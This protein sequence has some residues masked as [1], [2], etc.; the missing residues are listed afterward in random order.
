MNLIDY[1]FD[2]LIMKENTNGT[3][4]RIIAVFKD[5]YELFC[6]CGECFGRLKSSVYYGNKTEEFPTTGDFVLINY[7]AI[8]DSRI[9][10]TLPRKSKFVRNDFSGHAAA[11]V[12]NFLE[13]I[14]AVNFDYV[15]IMA[16]LNHD[17][18]IKRIERYLTLAFTS[19]AVPVII[20]SKAD[21]VN[22]YS[23]QV[24]SVENIATGVNVHV[25]SAVTG[26]GLDSLSIYL[27]PQKTIVFLGS[28]GVGKSS[29]VNALAGE[30]IMTVNTIREDDSKGKHTTTVRQLIM[31][32]CGVMIID[33]PGMREMGMWDVKDG[34]G[35]AFIDVEKYFGKCKFSD[36]KHQSEPGCAVKDAIIN[37]ELS[38]TRW[39]SY[40]NLKHEAK[41]ADDKSAYLKEK[42]HWYKDIAKL[43]KQL[44]KSGHKNK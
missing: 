21:L 16:S 14:V 25:I 4:A 39:D 41:Y 35:E 23:E 36:C 17:F 27:K 7:N 42:Q 15:F 28:S 11:Y 40:I 24:I 38:K 44:H 18:N 37:G 12:K 22:D 34:L 26:F 29:L 33:T 10:K 31:L 20:L 1:G 9:I 5:R 30:E 13:Q 8:G 32:N 19:G 2:P 43:N 3:P 6:E